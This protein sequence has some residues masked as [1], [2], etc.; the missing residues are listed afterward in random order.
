M[1]RIINGKRYDTETATEVAD[2][3]HSNRSDFN[4][5]DETLYRTPKGNW[6]IAGEGNAR[7]KYGEKVDQSTWGPGK[8]LTP[9]TEDEAREWLEQHHET[10]ALERYFSDRIEDA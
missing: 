10:E 2:H 4:Y 5:Y 6:F 8:G 9:L 3:Q 1:K 7:S